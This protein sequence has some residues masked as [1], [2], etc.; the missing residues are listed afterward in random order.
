[1]VL[2][3]TSPNG[4]FTVLRPNLLHFTPTLHPDQKPLQHPLQEI[5]LNVHSIKHM[6]QAEDCLHVV[7]PE[8]GC[9]ACQYHKIQHL[10]YLL[11]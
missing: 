10:P 4:S 8:C 11:A 6:Q 1:M 5:S 2:L 3:P 9:F 7:R